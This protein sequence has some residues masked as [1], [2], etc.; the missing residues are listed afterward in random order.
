MSVQ[1]Q[2]WANFQLKANKGK[3]PIRLR[4][5]PL[6]DTNHCFTAVLLKQDTLPSGLGQEDSVPAA[7]SQVSRDKIEQ[8]YL[9][10]SCRDIPGY[11]L[12]T[13][14]DSLPGIVFSCNYDLGWSRRSLS[15]GCLALTG[16][17]PE[18]LLG[19]CNLTYNTL[20]DP[21]DLPQLLTAISSAVNS[22]QAYT[23]EYRIR[24]K[25]GQLK[26]F[27]E[28]GRGIF[29]EQS[30]VLGLEG[31]ITDISQLKQAEA[32]LRHDAFY[33][34]LTG[35]PNR[36]LFMDR[37]KYCIKRVKRHPDQLFAV[38]FLD[39][40]RFKVVNDSLGHAAGDQLLVEVADRLG[41]CVRESDT[42]GRL[43]GD[44]FTVLLEGIKDLSDALQ[45]CSRIQQ[46]LTQP[47]KLNG[48]E[49]LITVSTGVALST[50]GYDDP[51][52]LLHN[53]DAAM[54]RAKTQG[55]AQWEVFTA[56]MHSN[57]SALLQLEVDLRRAI[58]RQEFQLHYQPIY[59]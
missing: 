51:E 12:Q 13:L 46:A 11:N 50:M 55:K 42:L 2:A 54:Y 40:D 26:W 20:I 58:E 47:F 8:G 1:E 9:H 38:L 18:E 37:L 28:Q 3:Q 23:V 25:S 5:A 35:L 49:V 29:D 53:A 30:Q 15:Q 14:I 44:E 7:S 31:F 32:Q 59:H 48:R 56:D 4:I 36:A 33:D 6:S 22:Q 24:T 27:L 52:Q 21:D 39:L 34:K 19:N 43:G 10:K 45:V 16:Y 41:T 17:V 57:A